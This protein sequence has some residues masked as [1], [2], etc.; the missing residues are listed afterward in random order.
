VTTEV[1]VVQR[2]EQR[3][4][5]DTQDAEEIGK[6]HLGVSGLDRPILTQKPVT[7]RQDGAQPPCRY[8]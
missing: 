8:S 4:Q 5:E 2:H 6:G 3:D 7:G 1:S